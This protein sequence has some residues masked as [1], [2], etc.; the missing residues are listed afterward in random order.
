MTANRRIFLNVIATYGRSLLSLGAG[1]FTSRW[2]LSALG[3][4]SY[5]VYGVVGVILMFVGMIDGLLSASV[6]RYYAFAIGEI[7]V[8]R[9]QEGAV[10]ECR[11]WFN[12]A[13]VIHVVAA[14]VIV[15]IAISSGLWAIENY[16]NIPESLKETTN[17][18][19]IFS[20]AS[21]V[22]GLVCAPFRAMYVAQQLIAELTIYSVATTILNFVCAFAL[23]RFGGDKLFL[24]SLYSSILII[25]PAVVIA[26]RGVIKFPYCKIALK[27]YFSRTKIRQILS[28]AGWQLVGWLGM[29]LRAQGIAII[30][31]KL[32]GVAYNSTMTLTNTINGHVGALSNSLTGAFA[33]A[34]TN[35]A[36]ASNREGV[37]ALS[38]NACRFGMV[39]CGLFAIP[40][41]LEIDYVL[42]LW[43][44][45]PP[46]QLAVLS[47]CMMIVLMLEKSTGG[48]LT[49]ILASGNIKAHEIWHCVLFILSLLLCYVFVGFCSMGMVG[50]GASFIAY[51][52]AFVVLRV[53]LWRTQLHYPCRPW[54]LQTIRF[55]VVSGVSIAVPLLIQHLM[56][57]SFSRLC[58]SAMAFAVSYSILCYWVLI[59]K[60]ERTILGLR[61]RGKVKNL[62]GITC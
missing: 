8:S 29:T 16:F 6:S 45:N 19:L 55:L 5:G 11:Q 17:W 30:V 36:G 32:M 54:V 20:V 38:L 3:S 14:L 4:E 37:F 26:V 44:T 2:V 51:A 57:P 21:V 15:P 34:V 50:V 10:E 42:N 39:L 43:L 12:S 58:C 9:D 13:L 56:K 28:F 24:H 18:V 41:S 53:V 59:E 48:I 62:F 52:L 7:Q 23:L 25:A 35:A 1:I 60:D 40:L 49:A 31:N 47:V 46:P 22:T 33:P 61:V 27:R